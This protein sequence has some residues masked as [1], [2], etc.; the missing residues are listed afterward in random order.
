MKSPIEFRDLV[1]LVLVLAI[2]VLS[3]DSCYSRRETRDL[4]D[5]V[6]TFN[7]W[8]IGIR[9]DVEA[10]EAVDGMRSQLGEIAIVS[11]ALAK[12]HEIE[13]G[14]AGTDAGE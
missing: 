9:S 2:A 3:V 10:L 1:L 7:Q 11:K 14:D 8:I 6:D 5:K 12:Y 13:L 4:S